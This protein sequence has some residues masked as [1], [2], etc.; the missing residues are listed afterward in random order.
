LF[1]SNHEFEEM[2]H[3]KA[4][5]S[6]DQ[7]LYDMYYNTVLLYRETYRCAFMIKDH[8]ILETGMKLAIKIPVNLDDIIKDEIIASK[9]EDIGI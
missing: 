9:Q 1:L 5:K 6:S 2:Y 8:A 4:K 3:F 7:E